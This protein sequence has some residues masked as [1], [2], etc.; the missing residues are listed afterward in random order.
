MTTN[1]PP[2]PLDLPPPPILCRLGVGVLGLLVALSALPWVYYSLNHFG[3]FDWGLFGF[4][5]ITILAGIYAILLGLGKF[6]D[7]WALGVTAIAGSILVAL[8][9]GLFVGFIKA[10]QI[11]F[12]S[13]APLAKYTFLG[14]AATIAA[15]F[16]LASIAV[17]SRNKASLPFLIKSALTAAP[18]A[19]VAALMHFNIGPG[20]WINTTLKTSTGTGGLQAIL[21]LTL[22]LL[23]ITLISIAAHLLIRAYETGRPQSTPSE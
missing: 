10:K 18:I 9:F 7:G 23:F 6:K 21:A 20:T 16:A 14:R 5:L 8:V 22:G 11:D 15:F 19:I 2:S 17:F 13:L 12:P 3:G 4:E 1:K